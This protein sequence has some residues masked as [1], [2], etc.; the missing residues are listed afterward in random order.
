MRHDAAAPAAV[1]KAGHPRD[2]VLRV[3]APHVVQAGEE[4]LDP[5]VDDVRLVEKPEGELLLLQMYLDDPKGV[6]RD[7]ADLAAGEEDRSLQL[8]LF[9]AACCGRRAAGMVSAWSSSL[10]SACRAW[11]D[12]PVLL[13]LRRRSSVRAR[14]A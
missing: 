12:S 2:A 7:A 8:R 1:A 3:V 4:E 11:C 14:A 10:R 13:L 9:R 5:A 6:F